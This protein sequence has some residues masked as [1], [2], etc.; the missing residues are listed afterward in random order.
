MPKMIARSQLAEKASGI[1]DHFPQKF[2]RRA[3]YGLVRSRSMHMLEDGM[4]I[5]MDDQKTGSLQQVWQDTRSAQLRGQNGGVSS[6]C[7]GA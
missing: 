7:S 2:V 3:G 6:G 4:A 1:R 5:P